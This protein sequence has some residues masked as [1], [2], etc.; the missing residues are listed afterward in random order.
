MPHA[1]T[2]V[3]VFAYLFSKASIIVSVNI[4]SYYYYY[5][6][7]YYYFISGCLYIY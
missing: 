7:Y 6:Y 1:V 5:Y 4:Q 3:R 2:A